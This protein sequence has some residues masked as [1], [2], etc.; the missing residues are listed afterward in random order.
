MKKELSSGTL[1]AG[2]S[3]HDFLYLPVPKDT[4]GRRFGF[5]FQQPK[6]AQAETSV[7]ELIF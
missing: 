1:S 2:T 5:G 7:M 3:A 4:L 6:P